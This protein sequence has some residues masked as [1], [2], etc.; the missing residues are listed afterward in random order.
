MC[1]HTQADIN[2][3][4]RQLGACQILIFE[5]LGERERGTERDIYTCIYIH[6]YT[7]LHIY[8][9]TYTYIYISTYIYIYTYPLAILISSKSVLYPFHTFLNDS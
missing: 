2:A 8:I 6:I 4:E 7:Y 1:R 5:C 9:Y 3:D